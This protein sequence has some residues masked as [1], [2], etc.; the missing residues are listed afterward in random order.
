MA[1][2]VTNGYFRVDNTDSDISEYSATFDL[3][4]FSVSFWVKPDTESVLWAS[5][6]DKGDPGGAVKNGWDIRR[7]G[8]R[9]R[10]RADVV[11][12][13]GTA[14]YFDNFF[15]DGQDKWFHVVLTVDG[16]NGAEN[17]TATTYVDGEAKSKTEFTYAAKPTEAMN[18]GQISGLIDEIKFY[19]GVL[20]TDEIGSLHTVNALPEPGNY[21]LF[22]GL[23]SLTSV[24]VRRR[25][26]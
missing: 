5:L 14:M 23:L 25:Q 11:N 10:V 19:D 3:D 2:N 9:H 20:T 12:T 8:D 26:R 24:M 6:A 13:E 4:K 22:V 15:D 1:L 18:F 17:D 7:W 21:A 16:G